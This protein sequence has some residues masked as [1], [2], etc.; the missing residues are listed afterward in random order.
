MKKLIIFLLLA[1]V[2]AF[3][4][5]S[6]FF[7]SKKHI[8]VLV[9]SKTESFR[10]ESIADGK[11]ALLKMGEEHGFPVDTTEDA[12]FFKEKTL[13][14]YNVVV[15]LNTTGDVLNDAQQLEFNR[16]IQAG[17]GYVGIHAA[18]DTEYDWPWYGK[19]VGAYF[20]GHPN[21]PNV[22]Q[23]AI[24]V[25]DAEHD[26][27]KHLPN[28]WVREDEWYNYKDINPDINV[29]LNLDETSYE[30]GT[31]GENHPITWYH[32]YDGGRAFYTG[33]GHT[34][35][36]F[37]EPEF[38]EMLWQGINYVV[39][40]G[41]PVDYS[42]SNVAPEENRFVKEVMDAGLFEP[43]EL[44]LLP[45]GRPIFVE[46]AGAI[47]IY[48]PE[49]DSAVTVNQMEVF[50]DLEDGLIG[51]A[52]DPNFKDNNWIYLYYSPKDKS[53]NRLSRFDFKN[54]A[55]DMTTE[56][57]VLEVEVQ[58]DE[59][60]HAG[61]SV[62]FG[63]SG[64]LYLS[65][66]DNTNPH[67]SNGYS[68]SDEREGRGPWDAQKSSANTNDLRGKV[69]RIKPEADGSYSIPDGN[70]FPKDGSGGRPEI[71]VMGCRNPYRISID[72]RT[73]FLY[74]GDVGPDA[75]KD[76][77]GRG[78]MG[79]D[80]VN[81]ARQAGFF[82]WPYFVGDNKAYNDYNFATE[83]SGEKHNPEKPINDSPHNTGANELPPAQ[84][85]FIWYPYG[86]SKEFPLMGD[87]G[88][89]AMAGP[90]YYYEDY[91]DNEGKFPEYYNGK[92]FS[93]DWM[94]GRILAN[95]LDEEGNFVRME[96]FLPS[97]EWN[98]VIDMLFSP[99]GDIYLLEY[100]TVWFSENPDAR[101]VHLKYISGNRQPIAKM[102]AST[103][104]GAVPLSVSFDASKSIDFD[105]DD[106]IYEWKVENDATKYQGK[107]LNYTFEK[108]G[109]FT[110]ELTVKDPNG[111]ISRTKEEI[112]AGNEAPQIKW[113]IKGNQ[114]FFTNQAIE[115]E[116]EVTDKEDGSLT[117]GIDP[118]AVFVSVDYLEQGFDKNEIA[119]GHKAMQEASAFILGKKLMEASDCNSCHQMEVKSVG[120]SYKA[121]AEK[122]KDDQSA[123]SYLGGKIISGGGGVWGETAMAAHPQLS[124]GEAEQMS[125]YILSLVDV[126]K[127]VLPTSLSPKGSYT[128]DKHDAAN[129]QGVY[130]LTAAYTDKGS[131]KVGTL[132]ARDVITLRSPI[133]MAA[134]YDG[135]E[136]ATKFQLQAGQ[137]PGIEEDLDI[138]IGMN[139]GYVKYAD[140][141]LTGVTAMKVGIGQA[142][143]YM[144]G[145]TM[146]WRLDA[147]D[148]ELFATTSFEQGLT[149]MGLKDLE[150]KANPTDGLHDLYVV[151]KSKDENKP[152]CVLI[153]TAFDFGQIN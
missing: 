98:N 136:K 53:V 18:A 123:V 106:L 99:N 120:P 14:K 103:I 60:C 68:P 101:L 26:C 7:S 96:Q 41:K 90:V 16:F 36:T 51:M 72:Q 63:P 64:L 75:G 116:V 87:G 70:L 22:R 82:G 9:F 56:K 73:G 126:A 61:G 37:T 95:T 59:C 114:A 19:L 150:V 133:V 11:K 23:G 119:L 138:V 66:G 80:E 52:L 109:A 1:A 69:L 148:G 130:I 4:A 43:M 145:G 34:P 21:N 94:R 78:P 47:K 91:A 74:W 57:M 141:D 135:I 39:G 33:L 77:L 50:Y 105:G 127:K 153:Y 146:E 55:V 25:K 117:A 31:N 132:T 139:E 88:R 100:G 115:Y 143:T 137:V 93:Y 67:E 134:E 48:N 58:R 102:T 17:G 92:F 44:E 85:A 45:D 83:Q 24:E 142:P 112:L 144:G 65:T 152:A 110:V 62:E 35:E 32:E 107:T 5:Y 28:P 6:Y 8:S 149:D 49:V 122:Y 113:K 46:R 30:G 118:A 84:P 147:P 54:D 125:K 79:H 129:P 12:S 81:Q 71:Y 29:L 20:N 13:Q 27:T 40:E 151:F 86:N 38:V 140:M 131:R 42:Q 3:A 128:F 97:L 89:N 121:I 10:H 76:S 124:K 108:A 2:V 104:V 111:E 15:F